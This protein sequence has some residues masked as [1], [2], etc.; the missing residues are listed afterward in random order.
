MAGLL[1]RSAG[2]ASDKFVSL[3][4]GIGEP[5]DRITFVSGQHTKLNSS[6]RNEQRAG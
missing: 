1:A 5:D 6:T 3:K 2:S 4:G